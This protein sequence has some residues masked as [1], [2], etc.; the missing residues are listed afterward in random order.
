MQSRTHTGQAIRRL[1]PGGAIALCVA[2]L[3][4]CAAHRPR[5]AV[6]AGAAPPPLTASY[7]RQ[8]KAGKTVYRLDGRRSSAWIFVD[9]AGPLA[10]F[11]HRHVIEVESPR[12]FAQ[13]N[14]DGVTHAEVRFSASKLH[15]DPPAALARFDVKEHLSDKDRAGTRQHMLGSR[16]LDARRYPW[17]RLVVDVS[18]TRQGTVALKL[19]IVLHGKSKDL[20]VPASMSHTGK[21]WMVKGQFSLEQSD[22]GITPYSIMLGALRVKNR[23]HIRYDLVFSPWNP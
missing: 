18:H 17:I 12:G 1:A 10:G 3:G 20:T 13:V 23:I 5:Q 21:D 4:A 16:V 2:L 7:A 14:V 19:H 9:K 22:F 11:G 8:A 6:S 15:V